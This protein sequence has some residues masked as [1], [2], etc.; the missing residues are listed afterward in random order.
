M[1]ANRVDGDE[2]RSKDDS[3]DEDVEEDTES[4]G[5]DVAEECCAGWK[6]VL[7]EA[8]GERSQDTNDGKPSHRLAVCGGRQNGLNQHDE[9]ASDGQDDLGENAK[10]VRCRVHRFSARVGFVTV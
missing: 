4:V 8:G 5:L 10:D 9:H 3:A 2:Q 7:V 1:G 6:L